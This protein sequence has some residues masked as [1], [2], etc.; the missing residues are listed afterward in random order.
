MQ[1]KYKEFLFS[2]FKPEFNDEEYDKTVQTDTKAL[3]DFVVF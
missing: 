2:G 3:I 1:Q